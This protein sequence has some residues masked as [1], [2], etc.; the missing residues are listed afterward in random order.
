MIATVLAI[1]LATWLGFWS[2]CVALNLTPGSDVMFISASGAA[3]GRGA[4]VAAGVGVA[5][6]SL[7]HVALAVLGVAALIAA[8]ATAFAVLRWGGAA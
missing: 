7:V 3:G 4:G 8:S 6:G 2:A 5:F 1:P